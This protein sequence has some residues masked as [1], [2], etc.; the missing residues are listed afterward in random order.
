MLLSWLA[1]FAASFLARAATDL[2]TRWRA[3][4]DA[5]AAGRAEAVAES[6]AVA[7]DAIATARRVEAE[8]DQAHAADATDAAFDADF[9]RT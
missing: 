6:Q 1:S 9:R 8:A 3:E 7:L 4:A 2:W 5:K